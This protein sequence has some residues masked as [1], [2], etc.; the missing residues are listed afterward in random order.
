VS[1]RP[2]LVA[3]AFAGAW[4]LIAG[5]L[6]WLAHSL[7]HPLIEQ[8]AR[9]VAIPFTVALAIVPD[10]FAAPVGILIT[11][12]VCYALVWLFSLFGRKRAG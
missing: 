10:A 6:M 5:V 12:A 2:I 11:L 8:M 3:A 7:K 4:I 9:V 1:G